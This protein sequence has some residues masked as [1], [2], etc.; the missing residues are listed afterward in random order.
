AGNDTILA[1]AGNDTIDMS[2][3]GTS[4]PGNDSIDGGAGIDRVDYDGYA[5]SGVT[6]NL[7]TGAVSGGGDAGAGSATVSSIERFIGGGFNDA[8]TGGAANEFLD[9]RG[10]SDALDGGAGNDTLQGGA[11]SDTFLFTQTPGTA[12][13]DQVWDFTSGTDHIRLSA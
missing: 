1:G 7:A 6:A 12:N 4:S 5:K 11:G 2:T 10:G 8:F 9:G 3:G 13:A